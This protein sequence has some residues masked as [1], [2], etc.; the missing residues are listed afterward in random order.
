MGGTGST[1]GRA[2]FFQQPRG[3]TERRRPGR[4]SLGPVLTPFQ[5]D[6]VQ[7]TLGQANPLPT[8][9]PTP[10]PQGTTDIAAGSTQVRRSGR[11]RTGPRNILEDEF[12]NETLG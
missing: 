8:P 5:A 7:P 3:T 12:R 2:F 9:T 1:S 4:S 10:T 6:P 11:G